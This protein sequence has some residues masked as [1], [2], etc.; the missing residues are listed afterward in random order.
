MK[1]IAYASNR[2]KFMHQH[3]L[4]FSKHYPIMDDPIEECK[5]RL[6]EATAELKEKRKVFA[7]SFKINICIYIYLLF[8]LFFSIFLR[9]KL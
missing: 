8:F 7:V 5:Q 3:T 1:N 9:K 6:V 4:K 2:P